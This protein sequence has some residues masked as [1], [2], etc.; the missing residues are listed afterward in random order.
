MYQMDFS[1]F[2][3]L[4]YI[5]ICMYCFLGFVFEW[6]LNLCFLVLYLFDWEKGFYEIF[7]G[8]D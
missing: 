6:D 1:Y 3:D 5:C 2:L 8:W 4:C 7:L